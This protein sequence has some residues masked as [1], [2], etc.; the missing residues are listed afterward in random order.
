MTLVAQRSVSPEEFDRA[1]WEYRQEETLEDMSESTGSQFQRS[2]TDFSLTLLRTRHSPHLAVFG[3][4]L[5]LYPFDN[6]V[7]RVVPDNFV[8]LGLPPVE[9]SIYSFR[10]NE[11]NRPFWVLEYVSEPTQNKDYNESFVKY[12]EHLQVPYCTL[13]HPETKRLSMFAHDG[14]GYQEMSVDSQGRFLIPELELR[15]GLLGGWLRYWHRDELLPTAL[16]LEELQLQQGER[17]QEQARA[18]AESKQRELNRVVRLAARVGRSDI[19]NLAP[20]ATLEQ[21][22]SWLDELLG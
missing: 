13:F 21:L 7:R 20:Q 16:E 17:I 11:T 5:V 4:L 18:L 9:R 2:I 22:Q 12:E 15:V 6:K 19:V 1:E 10:V 8:T 3:E 14:T